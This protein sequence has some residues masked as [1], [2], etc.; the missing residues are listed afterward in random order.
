VPQIPAAHSASSEPPLIAE[1]NPLDKKSESPPKIILSDRTLQVPGPGHK[2]I[3]DIF[4]APFARHI[5]DFCVGG[6][7][8]AVETKTFC[9]KKAG[10]RKLIGS[11][12]DQVISHMAKQV[13]VGFN[14]AGVGRNAHATGVILTPACLIILQ[15]RLVCVGTKH[16]HLELAETAPLPL[17]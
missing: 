15:L 8:V 17:L 7:E 3:V 13:A 6:L 14:F 2:R 4:I 12:R 5:H 16:V 9:T 10:P 1:A 11:A